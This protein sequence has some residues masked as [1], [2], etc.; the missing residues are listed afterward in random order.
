MSDEEP[1]PGLCCIPSQIL[2]KDANHISIRLTPD[3]E[4]FVGPACCSIGLFQG[5]ETV[6]VFNRDDSDV[7]CTI[8]NRNWNSR[9]FIRNSF[10]PVVN[11]ELVTKF[12]FEHPDY[13][14]YFRE[15][16]YLR[17]S[18]P[19]ESIELPCSNNSMIEHGVVLARVL[20]QNRLCEHP[21]M[22]TP[23]DFDPIPSSL[24]IEG[25]LM[26]KIRHNPC[27]TCC[28]CRP[29]SIAYHDNTLIL[30]RPVFPS[31]GECIVSLIADAICLPV[32]CIFPATYQLEER[33]CC[34][35]RSRNDQIL[36]IVYCKR[37]CYEHRRTVF[38]G[39]LGVS[40]RVLTFTDRSSGSETSEYKVGVLEV[41]HKYG[42]SDVYL[43]EYRVEMSRRIAEVQS[44]I[45]LRGAIHA[46]SSPIGN[47]LRQSESISEDVSYVELNVFPSNNYDSGLTSEF[48]Q[49][50]ALVPLV[51]A[52]AVDV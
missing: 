27:S 25:S 41:T 45:E 12:N 16:V 15:Q 24:W 11:V 5:P 35:V 17:V 28:I 6:I 14:S 4:N 13:Q 51:Q 38:E 30:F 50:V 29:V 49:G 22:F 46:V 42:S 40:Y 32:S 20:I 34:F 7:R 3:L 19:S 9:F 37:L 1:G 48:D 39:V 10:E 31:I 21:P 33:G 52:A 26:T 43:G 2:V 47:T 23:A 36:C 18:L 44:F 8:Y